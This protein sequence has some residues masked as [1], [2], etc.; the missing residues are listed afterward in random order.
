MKI[1]RSEK[2][3]TLIELLVTIAILGAIM[4]G[5]S[6]AVITIMKVSPQNNNWAIALRQVQNAGY[7]ISRDVQMAQSVGGDDASTAESEF[8]TLSW[9]GWEWTEGTG[10]GKK[11]YTNEYYVSYIYD[12][13]NKE[14]MR[15]QM[16]TTSEYD[17][18]GH[19]LSTTSNTHQIFIA[20]FITPVP[21]V[22][23]GNEIT[24]VL[25][26]TKGGAEVGRTYEIIPRP[27]T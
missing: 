2:G 12:E 8:L 26:A 24:V 4:G 21:T 9:I 10:S 22:T 11:Q 7:W 16:T 23:F 15:R 3:F 25:S 20:D 6:A 1:V 27:R 5:M 17:I 13:D 19:L 14:I 18:Y